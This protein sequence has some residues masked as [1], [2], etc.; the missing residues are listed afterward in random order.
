MDEKTQKDRIRGSLIG[1]AIGDALGYPVEFIDSYTGIQRRYGDAGITRLDVRQ[2]WKNEDNSTG[3]AWISDD[4]QMTLFT[5]CGILNAK[6]KGSAPI[7]SICEAYIEW[8]YTQLG[9]RSKRFNEC[10]IGDIPELNQR[11][12]PGNTCLTALS[13]IIAGKSPHNNSKGCGGVMRI[14][15]IPLY[16]LAQGRISNIDALDRLAADTAELTHQHPLGFIPAVLISHLIYRLA[17]D[18]HPEKETFKEYIREGLESTQRMFSNHAEEVEKFVS[19]V[20]KAILLSDISTDDVRT[21][22]DELGGGWVAEE[23]V[24]IAIYCTLTHFENFEK[25]MIAAVNHAGDSDS[26]GAVTGNLLGATIG[27]DAIPQFY[28]DDLELHDVVLH[29]ADDLYHGK[30]TPK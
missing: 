26:T 4:T 7:P 6:E 2:W 18:E 27:Y 11:R 12:A 20:K 22:E 24:A 3:K 16:G 1:G 13:D 28:K 9:R 30:T 14:A 5:A 8:Y 23:T 17:T 25:A 21:I 19:L 10:W 15:P 29:I